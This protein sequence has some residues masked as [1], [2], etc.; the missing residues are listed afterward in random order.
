MRKCLRCQTEMLED[1]DIKVQGG[2]YGITITDSEKI[3]A[4]RLGKPK[5]AVCP[6]C[7]EVSVYIE[8]VDKLKK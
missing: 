6:N 8:D 4:A 5:V 2:G 3:F 1:Y 7:G